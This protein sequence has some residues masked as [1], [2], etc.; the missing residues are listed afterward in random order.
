MFILYLTCDIF[1]LRSD[2]CE[3][4][5]GLMHFFLPGLGYWPVAFSQVPDFYEELLPS[6]PL[7]YLVVLLCH[8]ILFPFPLLISVPLP[9]LSVVF[10]S[11]VS[12][13]T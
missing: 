13:I 11:P 7:S 5:L 2:I 9:D 12:R 3:L 8:G 1:S 10:V 4:L 6:L